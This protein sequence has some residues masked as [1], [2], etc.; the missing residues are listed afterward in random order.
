MYTV[1][2]EESESEVEN[3]GFF[4]PDL[5]NQENHKKIE[6]PYF[7]VSFFICLFLGGRLITGGTGYLTTHRSQFDISKSQGAVL[8][9]HNFP[10]GFSAITVRVPTG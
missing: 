10:E 1:F 9:K 2:D 6:N 7:P 3:P 4:H 8:G 5:E